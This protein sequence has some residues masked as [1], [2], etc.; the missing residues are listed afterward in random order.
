MKETTAVEHNAVRTNSLNVKKQRALVIQ[1]RCWVMVINN[2]WID[3][4]I[5][6]THEDGRSYEIEFEDT[7]KQ[8]RMNCSHVKPRGFDIPQIHQRF[9]QENL[10]P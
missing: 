10:V 7:G 8:F 3:C 5:T 1:E 9:Q 6:D 2:Q 4:F